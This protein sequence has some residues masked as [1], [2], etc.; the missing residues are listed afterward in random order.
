MIHRQHRAALT[1]ASLLL[2]GC[3]GVSG[4]HD[5]ARESRDL[6]DFARIESHGELDVE[7][8]QGDSFRVT[9]SIDDNLLD[10][11]ET[12]VRDETLIIDQ[13]LNFIDIVSGPHVLVEMPHLT[14]VHL[15]GSG[16][17]DA[18]PFDEGEPIRLELGGSGDLRFEGSAPRIEADN[19]GSGAI[20]LAG[21]TDFA[22]LVVRGSGNIE[23]RDL[24][25]TEAS[26]RSTSS[27]DITASVDGE[28]DAEVSGSGD[29][30]LYGG[31]T[32]RERRED[33]SGAIRT[34]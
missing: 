9:V 33:G 31:A 15:Y 18:Q 19:D 22:E 3:L 5:R 20:H 6:A 34:H 27:G 14:F 29:I 25:A 13:D 16:D 7:V 32:L 1:S 4:S 23:A 12:R 8:R 17:L 24:Q 2:T 28:V 11:V 30:D 10:R 26:L 21:T